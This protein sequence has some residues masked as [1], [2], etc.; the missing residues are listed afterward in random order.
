MTRKCLCHTWWRCIRFRILMESMLLLKI[1]F[2]QAFYLVFQ[3]VTV[4]VTVSHDLLILE[5]SL[6]WRSIVSPTHAEAFLGGWKMP[7]DSPLS[8]IWLARFLQF[9][10]HR[11]KLGK[12]SMWLV[13]SQVCINVALDS[14]ISTFWSWFTKIGRMM[15]DMILTHLQMWR[16]S[17]MNLSCWMI[18]KMSWKMQVSFK[19]MRMMSSFNVGC[20]SFECRVVLV[21]KV[22]L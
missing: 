6:F 12:S 3:Q 7:P 8:H 5:L 15:Q 1:L 11:L 13:F 18:M 16:T 22:L 21:A 20:I 2:Q 4:T 10:A 19:M 14:K 9:R 17:T